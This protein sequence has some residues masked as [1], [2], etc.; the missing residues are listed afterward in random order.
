MGRTIR[1]FKVGDE[2][3]GYLEE[4]YAKVMQHANQC[5]SPS[6]RRHPVM[7]LGHRVE[8]MVRKGRKPAD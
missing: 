3:S 1:H 4:D 6:I 7:I 2:I 5:F 8:T